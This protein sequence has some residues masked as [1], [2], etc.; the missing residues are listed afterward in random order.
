MRRGLQKPRRF[1]LIIS[2]FVSSYHAL[3]NSCKRRLSLTFPIPADKVDK[4]W[5]DGRA[6]E[7]AGLLNRCTGY[8]L[9]RGFE[10]R[11]LRFKEI[12]SS[13]PAKN[14]AS[15]DAAFC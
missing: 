10:S 3:L 6:A 15:Q 4:P 11:S 12:W 8:N 5:R 7:G 2:H 14:A 9:Y 13:S 1:L